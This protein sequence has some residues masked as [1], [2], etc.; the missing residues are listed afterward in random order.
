MSAW[1]PVTGAVSVRE[2]LVDG[3]VV[4]AEA[5]AASLASPPPSL[6]GAPLD[7]Y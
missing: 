2:E 4:E 3:D 6:A 5:P 7:P 1:L